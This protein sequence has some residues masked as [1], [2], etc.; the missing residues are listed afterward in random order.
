MQTGET[1]DGVTVIENLFIPLSDGTRLAARLG[2]PSMPSKSRFLLFL[3][4]FPT[5]KRTA[6]AGVTSRC[7]AGLPVMA[8]L[9]SGLIN[10]DQASRTVSSMMNISS[11]NRTTR[12]K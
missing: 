9:R 3:N 12:L 11:K 5:A 2:F 7:M 4:S 1:R 6:R 8:R 10:E